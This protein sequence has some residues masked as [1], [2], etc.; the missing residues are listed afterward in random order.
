MSVGEPAN[1][2]WNKKAF[3]SI[4]DEVQSHIAAIYAKN[5]QSDVPEGLMF[6]GHSDS[7]WKLVPS[8]LRHKDAL[9][10]ESNIFQIFSTRARDTLHNSLSD[11]ELLTYMQHYGVPTRLLDWSDSFGVALY[12]AVHGQDLSKPKAAAVWLLNGF[13]WSDKITNERAI[14][15]IGS[16][17]FPS[18]ENHFIQKSSALPGKPNLEDWPFEGALP[19][20][21][22]WGHERIVA[23]RGLF[24][25]HGRSTEPLEVQI[26]DELILRK[27]EIPAEAILHARQWL[28][29]AGI[30]HY[31]VFPDLEGLA[32]NLKATYCDDNLKWWQRISIL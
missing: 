19:I 9:E 23:Q 4:L 17:I 10:S 2:G 27:F 1:V 28:R 24:T 30:D 26:Q 18:Y 7:S 22:P 11:W 5:V 16:D 15:S 25:V 29:L 14:F 3:Q 13:A 12:F 6:R 21:A 20:E 8:L 31:S 32:E